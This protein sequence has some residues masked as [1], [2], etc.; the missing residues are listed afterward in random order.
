MF[1]KNEAKLLRQEFWTSFG[2]SFPREWILYNTNV[3]G[4][5]FK[6]YFDTKTAYVA[7]C[8]D[9][10]P[11]KQQA[12]WEQL[13]SHKT[14]LETDFLPEVQF[15]KNFEVSEDKILSV[16]YVSTDCKVSIHNKSTWRIAMEFLNE[17][18]LKFEAFYDIYENT[19]K[20]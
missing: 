2:K 8:M 11:A 5:S 6:F 20:I 17:T 7:L 4:L 18:M 14:I 9:M 3:K 12:Y 10:D 19:V 16:A 13:L 1:S 15:E